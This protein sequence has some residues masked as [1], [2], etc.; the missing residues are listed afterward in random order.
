MTMFRKPR[1]QDGGDDGPPYWPEARAFIAQCRRLA[2]RPDRDGP[3]PRSAAHAAFPHLSK[4]EW[5]Q[6]RL[7]DSVERYLNEEGVADPDDLG[8]AGKRDLVGFVAPYI[9][10][11]RQI[12]SVAA[13]NPGQADRLLKDHA[14]WRAAVAK[15]PSR[16]RRGESV[17]AALQRHHP[18][19]GLEAAFARG[20]DD[21]RSGEW[22]RGARLWFLL[23][24][25][26]ARDRGIQPET[27]PP[28]AALDGVDRAAVSWM[29]RTILS[30]NDSL[31]LMAD[32]AEG[33]DPESHPAGTGTLLAERIY[34]FQAAAGFLLVD[35]TVPDPL[36]TG[37]QP[38][39]RHCPFDGALSLFRAAR[40]HAARAS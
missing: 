40:I 24:Y 25:A 34:P 4:A 30:G 31:E 37:L 27:P 16:V 23:P 10:T 29:H 7:A 35:W 28:F 22:R 26:V 12:E 18:D 13:A 20:A 5:L 6:V 3:I 15:G 14:T 36:P 39:S 11:T 19:P 21:L 38:V 32:A 33:E 2:R 1:R 17:G 9:M 8:L